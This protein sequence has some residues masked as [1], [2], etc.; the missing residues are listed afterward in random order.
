MLIQIHGGRAEQLQLLRI[1]KNTVGNADGITSALG[2]IW[3][4]RTLG[5]IYL[6]R[7][8]A[9]APS[10]GRKEVHVNLSWLVPS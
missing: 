6:A 5:P 3:G 2:H 1:E 4:F 7:P 9:V 10:K 8:D